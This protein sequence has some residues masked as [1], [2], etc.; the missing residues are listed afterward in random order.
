MLNNE[1]KLLSKNP[2]LFC[3]ILISLYACTDDTAQQESFNQSATAKIKQLAKGLKT[4]LST[5][6]QSGGPIAAVKACNIKAP[7]ITSQLNDE[8]IIKRTS[9]KLRNPTNAPDAWEKQVLYSFEKQLSSG[10]PIEQL[11]YKEKIET[12]AGASFRMMR[13]IPTQG[14]CLTCHGDTNDM[15]D[16]LTLALKQAYPN[17]LATGYQAGQIRGAFSVSQSIN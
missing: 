11:V 3:V 2:I 9:L 16:E 4:E 17:D 15:S 14:V 8:L 12:E 5:A 6:M 1:H 7:Q 10:T 13:A